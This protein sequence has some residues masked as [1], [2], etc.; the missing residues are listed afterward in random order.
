MDQQ[1]ASTENTSHY[2]LNTEML[3]DHGA[4]VETEEIEVIPANC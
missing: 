1:I 2:A 3:P 4:D